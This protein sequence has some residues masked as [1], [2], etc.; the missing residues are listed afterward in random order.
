PIACAAAVA[1]LDYIVKEDIPQ[2]SIELGNYFVKKLKTI[3]TINV[4]HRGLLIR[5]EIKGVKSAKPATM[6]MLVGKDRNPRVF[7][8]YGHSDPER[9]VAYTRIA[10]PPGAMTEKLIDEAI[11]KTIAPV[12]EGASENV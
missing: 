8:K 11:E 10:P 6:E 2:K 12:L 4:D 9:N 1:A 5:V 7:M 3:S